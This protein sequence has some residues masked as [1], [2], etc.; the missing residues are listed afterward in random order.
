MLK[1]IVKYGNS[2]ALILD[3]AILELLNMAEGS[4]VKIKTDGVSLIITPQQANTQETISPTLTIESTFQEASKKCLAQS[5]GG[6]DEKAAAFQ[7]GM[8]AICSRYNKMVEDCPEKKDQAIELMNQEI[9]TLLKNCPTTTTTELDINNMV[10]LREEFTKIHK[11]YEKLLGEVSSLMSTTEYIH[12]MALLSEKYQNN[13]NA[14]QSQEYL[15]A[16]TQLIAK[17]LPEYLVYQ[18]ELKKVGS[19]I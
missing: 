7:E 5:F 11:K 16:H 10:N 9:D 3:K 15:E 1:K 12:E 4:I 14:V 8:N 19:K 2:S 17:S 6:S 13:P 18:N